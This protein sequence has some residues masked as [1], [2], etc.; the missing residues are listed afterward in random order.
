[1]DADSFAQAYRARRMARGD[2]IPEDLPFGTRISNH[3]PR[4]G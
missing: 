1:M 4:A 2:N 3:A